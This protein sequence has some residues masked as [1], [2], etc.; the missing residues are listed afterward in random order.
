MRGGLV[1]RRVA[2]DLSWGEGGIQPQ[3]AYANAA[4]Q[5]EL[6][7]TVLSNIENVSEAEAAYSSCTDGR[8]PVKLLSG[9]AVPVREQIVGHVTRVRGGT[10]WLHLVG[11]PRVA[12]DDGRREA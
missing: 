8:V 11:G 6:L 3:P 4:A 12:G 2:D 5:R 7:E 9:E 1:A 10:T